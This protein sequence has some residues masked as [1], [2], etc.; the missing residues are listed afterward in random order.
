[1]LVYD[2]VSTPL[3]VSGWAL[4]LRQRACG[5]FPHP[6]TASPTGQSHRV[7]QRC[8]DTTSWRHDQVY[9]NSTGWPTPPLNTFLPATSASGNASSRRRLSSNQKTKAGDSL[10]PDLLF[11]C[12]RFKHRRLATKAVFSNWIPRGSRCAVSKLNQMS[13]VAR[14]S[15]TA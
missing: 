2:V 14:T 9:Y 3:G 8:L 7:P 6:Q 5:N 12:N 13:K 4:M 11:F 15:S 10:V 1:M